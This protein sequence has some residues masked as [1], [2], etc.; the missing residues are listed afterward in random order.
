MKTVKL[1]AIFLL[2]IFI[3]IFISTAGNYAFAKEYW[4]LLDSSASLNSRQARLRNESAR[5]YAQIILQ[6]EKGNTV[7]IIDFAENIRTLEPVNNMGNINNFIRRIGRSGRLTDIETALNYFISNP[8]SDQREVYLFTDGKVDVA[9]SRCVTCPPT[10]EDRASENRITGNIIQRLLDQEPRPVINTIGL[11]SLVDREFL[12]NIS[13]PTG[14]GTKQIQDMQDML[15]AMC[16]LFQK[17]QSSPNLSMHGSQVTIDG[18]STRSVTFI[19]DSD[20]SVTPPGGIDPSE[21]DMQY[22]NLPGLGKRMILINEPASGIYNVHSSAPH[23]IRIMSNIEINIEDAF[24]DGRKKVYQYEVLPYHMTLS[25]GNGNQNVMEKLANKYI[26]INVIID[27][28]CCGRV[29]LEQTKNDGRKYVFEKEYWLNCLLPDENPF[30]TNT[31]FIKDNASLKTDYPDTPVGVE[32]PVI[33]T[34]FNLDIGEKFSP[35]SKNFTK[36]KQSLFVSDKIM[37]ELMFNLPDG[38]NSILSTKY[39][40][41]KKELPQQKHYTLT[42]D[43]IGKKAVYAIV[44]CV[45]RRNQRIKLKFEKKLSVSILP[46]SITTGSINS[47]I[48]RLPLFSSLPFTNIKKLT[49]KI[50]VPFKCG[51]NKENI[52]LTTRIE[53]DDFILDK[54]TI[55]LPSTTTEF[56]LPLKPA[57]KLQPGDYSFKIFLDSA[58]FLKEPVEY[59]FNFKIYSAWLLLPVILIFAVILLVIIY[60]AVF[61]LHLF[62]THPV[63]CTKTS[64]GSNGKWNFPIRFF[65]PWRWEIEKNKSGGKVCRVNIPFGNNDFKIKFYEKQCEKSRIGGGTACNVNDKLSTIKITSV[66]F[67]NF[68]IFCGQKQ[69]Y[70]VNVKMDR[71]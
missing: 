41:G 64:P 19:G 14:G 16:D 71:K 50:E 11:G 65:P 34:D 69:N 29:E 51:I 35:E 67:F 36:K 21:L 57:R 23:N 49:K 31:Y 10:G 26:K 5:G 32:I 18:P 40:I 59:D 37:P 66:K 9:P 39:Y 27:G 56:S 24:P 68:R 28:S 22:S 4:L 48:S 1:S 25:A 46:F 12:E 55:T 53:S 3:F 54:K 38:I 58:N 63:A 8:S 44:E 47:C 62:F 60:L 70:I 45:S 30:I 7:G 20:L 6:M 61:L 13:S 42:K 33:K 17:N 15:N 43:D 2:F 52:L